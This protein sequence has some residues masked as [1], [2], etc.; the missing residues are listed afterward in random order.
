MTYHRYLTID[1]TRVFYREAG[2]P[3]APVL[4]LLH[5][6]PASSFMFRDL[7]ARLSERFHIIAPDYPGFGYS[8]APPD[9][10]AYT[11]DYLADIMSRFTGQLGLKTYAIYMQDFGGPVGFR[12]AS[13]YPERVSFFVIQNA[14]AYEEGLPDSFWAGAPA[15]GRALAGEFR[16]NSRGRNFARRAGVELHARRQ[17][18]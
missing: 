18:L 7:M 14:N 10:V 5:G 3:G 6:F 4:L 11:F 13:R 12:L 15:L 17:G 9:D 2:K 1:S 8:D 16:Q